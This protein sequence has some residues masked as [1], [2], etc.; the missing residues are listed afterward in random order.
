MDK[1]GRGEGKGRDVRVVIVGWEKKA[2]RAEGGSD[3]LKKGKKIVF[4][5]GEESK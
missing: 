1:K 3:N 4:D 2:Q 5:E